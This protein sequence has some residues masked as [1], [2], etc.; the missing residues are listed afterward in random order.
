MSA[1]YLKKVMDLLKMFIPSDLSMEWYNN[2]WQNNILWKFVKVK[3]KCFWV[4]IFLHFILSIT[5]SWILILSWI[6]QKFWREK[7]WLHPTT[8]LWGGEIWLHLQNFKI[9]KYCTR[10]PSF[11]SIY[12]FGVNEHVADLWWKMDLLIIYAD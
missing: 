2:Y 12:Q 7:R 1:W 4:I 9:K 8:L 3:E 10:S 5:L 11:H 6:R